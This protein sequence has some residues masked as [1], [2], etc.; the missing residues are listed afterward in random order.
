LANLPSRGEAVKLVVEDIENGRGESLFAVIECG[1]DNNREPAP[2]NNVMA[3]SHYVD[4]ESVDYVKVSGSKTLSLPPE[5]ALADI[6]SMKGRIE[7]A[8]AISVERHIL[9]IGRAHV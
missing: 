9:E 8:Q 2:L 6:K 5:V 4:G 3:S 7:Y 1:P